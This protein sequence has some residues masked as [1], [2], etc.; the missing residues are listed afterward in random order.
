MR[1]QGL[2]MGCA[3][4]CACLMVVANC[5]FCFLSLLVG[6]ADRRWTR[7]VSA[8]PPVRPVDFECGH[9]AAKGKGGRGPQTNSRT[10]TRDTRQNDTFRVQHA[11][12]IA[13]ASPPLHSPPVTTAVSHPSRRPVLCL[14]LPPLCARA[15]RSPASP[16]HCASR[17]RTQRSHAEPPPRHTCTASQRCTHSNSSRSLLLH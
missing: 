14:S 9:A 15:R 8:R 13:A 16:A 4:L 17:L 11:W 7:T 10:D 6:I 5:R 3:C 1:L 12:H 2:C